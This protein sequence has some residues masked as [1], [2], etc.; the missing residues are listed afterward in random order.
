MITWTLQTEKHC[1]S[2]LKHNRCHKQ[3]SRCNEYAPQPG[4]VT[5]LMKASLMKMNFD[6]QECHRVQ[7]LQEVAS[8]FTGTD[9]HVQC[10]I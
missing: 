4:S 9:R 7:N 6:L 3:I 10:L 8:H 1:N 2:L 5:A